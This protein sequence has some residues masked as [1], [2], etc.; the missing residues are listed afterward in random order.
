MGRGLAVHVHLC[1]LR[2]G[3]GLDEG[4]GGKTSE[5]LI[6]QIPQLVKFALQAKLICELLGEHSFPLGLSKPR[7]D[8]I[9]TAYQPR[10]H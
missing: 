8:L 2:K 6:E 4:H 10:E 7:R 5:G 1:T 9:E 3:S